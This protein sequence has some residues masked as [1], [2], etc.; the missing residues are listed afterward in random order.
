MRPSLSRAPAHSGPK[1]GRR[2]EGGLGVS[3]FLVSGPGCGPHLLWA[4][5]H[6][7]ELGSEG[8]SKL[9]PLS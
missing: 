3:G 5:A 4:G 9:G 6:L 2:K 8:Q 7:A 1:P